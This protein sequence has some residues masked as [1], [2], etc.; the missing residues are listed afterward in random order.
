MNPQQPN[1]VCGDRANV[2]QL[3]FYCETYLVMW[4]ANKAQHVGPENAV[5]LLLRVL[6]YLGIQ[7]P[8]HEYWFRRISLLC[9][10][11]G[12]REAAVLYFCAVVLS[13]ALHA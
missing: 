12:F 9:L 13:A 5:R 6:A 1:V 4:V 7:T 11:S 10:G 3:A 2:A 8:D